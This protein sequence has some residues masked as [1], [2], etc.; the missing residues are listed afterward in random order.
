MPIEHC[1]SG[2]G[3][4]LIALM[5]A[6]VTPGA[7]AG[8]AIDGLEASYR[9]LVADRAGEGGALIT[10]TAGTLRGL[11]LPLSYID[12]A[13]YWGDYV[14]ALPGNGLGLSLVSAIVTAAGGS[15]TVEAVLPRGSRFTVRLPGLLAK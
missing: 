15:I 1:R 9:F 14:C 5:V 6:A 13:D 10:A 7:R 4:A 8:T 3:A 2:L 12:S 11:R